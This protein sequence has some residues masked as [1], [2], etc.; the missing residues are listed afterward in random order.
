MYPEYDTETLPK[1]V[2]SFDNQIEMPMRYMGN[3]AFTG[4][5][6]MTIN[7]RANTDEEIRAFIDFFENSIN[8]GTEPFLIP[9]PFKGVE[10]LDVSPNVLVRFTDNL[11]ISKNNFPSWSTSLKLKVLE[12]KEVL[13]I[14]VDDT[15]NI[16]VDDA[17]NI[18][19]DDTGNILFSESEFNTN[20]NKEITYDL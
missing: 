3:R 9:A 16:L 11:S 4:E 19:V 6:Y 20:S 2:Y 18:L 7:L 13:G 17:G 14:L 8:F 1:I 5:E 12:Y 10:F 15:G